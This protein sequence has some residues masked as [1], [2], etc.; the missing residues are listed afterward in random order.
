MLAT[1]HLKTTNIFIH[2]YASRVVV[3]TISLL[4]FQSSCFYSYPNNLGT[5]H[6]IHYF[7]FHGKEKCLG[8][9]LIIDKI[10]G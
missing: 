5:T 7:S 8:L 2:R 6:E 1:K 4:G 10:S 9:S 3:K